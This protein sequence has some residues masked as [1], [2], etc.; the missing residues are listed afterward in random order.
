MA[1]VASIER[2]W[3]RE[4]LDS[5]GNPTVEVEIWTRGGARGRAIV[6][7]GASTG[8]HEALELRDGDA[9]RY[10]GRGVR[11]AVINVNQILGPAV[12]GLDAADQRSVDER[13]LELDPTPNKAM[14]GAN[15]V[16]GV[17]LAAAHAAA[18][19]TGEPLYR[20]LAGLYARESGRDARPRMPVPMT[21]M[22]SGGLH[23]GGNIDIQDVLVVPLGAADYPVALEWL[24]RIY[25]R[26]GEALQAAGYDGRLVGDEGGFGPRLPNNREAIAFVVRAIE[27][28]G[29]RP[30]EDVAIALDVAASHFATEAGTYRLR[31]EGDREL[32]AD[33]MI[34]RLEAWVAAFPI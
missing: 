16:L 11:R 10:D 7:S 18:A 4:V 9:R 20:H 19:A 3:G 25:R 21:N 12:V 5:R 6:P 14:L 28:A 27:R 22:I 8:R 23:A 29:L 31:S 15:A 26:L 32:T 2:V 1:S 34:D 13:L 24:V 17:S 33:E 30:G